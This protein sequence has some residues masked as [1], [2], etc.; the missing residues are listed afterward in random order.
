MAAA[1]G[2]SRLHASDEEEDD[3]DDTIDNEKDVETDVNGDGVDEQRQYSA[4]ICSKID[5]TWV[6]SIVVW[7][8]LTMADGFKVDRVGGF[9]SLAKNQ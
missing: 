5:N 4:F 7:N 1:A 3:T 6:S 9:W 2:C 8:Y